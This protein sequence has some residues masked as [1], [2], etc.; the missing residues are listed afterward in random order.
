[1]QTA[2]QIVDNY[3]AVRARLWGPA[4]TGRVTI[5]RPVKPP[6]PAPMQAP[7]K[8]Q[9]VQ[10]KGRKKGRKALPQGVFEPTVQGA[11]AK[12]RVDRDEV[13]SDCRKRPCV[14]ARIEIIQALHAAGWSYSGI[15]RRMNKDHSSVL[16]LH[17][18]Y[19]LHSEAY[20]RLA[21]MEMEKRK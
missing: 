8:R 1:M 10:V 4:T 12:W 20:L 13:F 19:A 5:H 21:Q 2:A 17:K 14:L 15:G 16:H 11:C 3:R 7:I 9:I 18:K 6:E